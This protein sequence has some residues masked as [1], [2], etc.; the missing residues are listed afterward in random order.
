MNRFRIAVLA[1]V[2]VVLLSAVVAFAG[3]QDF[4]FSN[5]SGSTVMELYVSS[6][7][8]PDWGSD[9]LGSNVLGSGQ[10]TFVSFDGSSGECYWDIMVVLD[11]GSQDYITGVDLCTVSEVSYP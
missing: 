5:Y 4:T 11:N 6:S 10:S 8:N 2:F 3:M 1:A 9:I 7:N